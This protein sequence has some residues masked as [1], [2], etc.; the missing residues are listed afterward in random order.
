[1]NIFQAEFITPECSTQVEIVDC[2]FFIF[3]EVKI[4]LDD[5]ELLYI[6]NPENYSTENFKFNYTQK[7][8]YKDKNKYD[9]IL[10]DYELNVLIPI[11]IIKK[12]SKFKKTSNLKISLKCDS[13][14]NYNSRYEFLKVES[15]NT[16]VETNGNFENH[17]FENENI[18]V[19]QN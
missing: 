11:I 4:S 16:D 10:T 18:R 19:L 12:N 7:Y 6:E 17:D 15:K 2:D 9:L 14:G 5:F 1:M 3:N 13:K 8:W